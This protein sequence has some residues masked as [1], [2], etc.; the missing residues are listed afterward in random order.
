MVPLDRQTPTTGLSIYSSA[1]RSAFCR[2]DS[3][4]NPLDKKRYGQ[5]KGLVRA[6]RLLSKLVSSKLES[7]TQ[8]HV[9]YRVQYEASVPK[10]SH[11]CCYKYVFYT[12]TF[13][14]LQY[15]YHCWCFK[16][17]QLVNKTRQ[18]LLAENISIQNENV[19]KNFQEKKYDNENAT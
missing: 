3:C 19:F 14:Y 9:F 17:N 18:V 8:G 16:F 5:Q 13:M 4:R 11:Q 15:H 7:T 6:V 1:G 12:C 2:G 10:H